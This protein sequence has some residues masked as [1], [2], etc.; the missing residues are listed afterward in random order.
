M[1][2]LKAVNLVL[3]PLAEAGSGR[4]RISGSRVSDMVVA[5]RLLAE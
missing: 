5:C 2:R 1:M 3:A 4:R